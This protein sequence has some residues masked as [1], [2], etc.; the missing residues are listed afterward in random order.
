[1]KKLSP[2]LN[3]V[4]LIAVAVLYFLHFSTSESVKET[5]IADSPKETVR[6]TELP[7]AGSIVYLDMEQLLLQYQYSVDL[8][9]EFMQE[10]ERLE[11]EM[12]VEVEKFEKT[13][14]AYQDKVA[15]GGFIS[16]AS[17]E[18][19]KAEILKQ[20]QDLQEL[21]ARLENEWLLKE[22]E[23]ETKLY[24]NII[25]YLDEISTT[26]NY[27]YVLSKMAGGNLLVGKVDLD[28]TDLVITELN[29]RYQPEPAK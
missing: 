8:N 3:I 13:A 7:D 24:N 14:T 4:L 21:Q 20:Q 27:Q 29:N 11:N 26:N 2:V 22:Q 18:N 6:A 10:K 12:R 1:M 15:R 28:I 23:L 19:Q 9:E 17:A 25:A 5:G 16:N